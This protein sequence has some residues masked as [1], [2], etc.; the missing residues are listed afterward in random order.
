MQLFFRVV[1]CV[2]LAFAFV[3]AD[4]QQYPR[5]LL[6][7]DDAINNPAFAS[8]W[9][10]NIGVSASFN[11]IKSKGNYLNDNIYSVFESGYGLE[12][13]VPDDYVED[14]G[15]AIRTRR[16]ILRKK[17][18][19]LNSTGF[20][21]LREELSGNVVSGR[22]TANHITLS[23][24]PPSTKKFRWPS[25]GIQPGWIKSSNG[26]TKFDLNAGVAVFGDPTNVNVDSWDADYAATLNYISVSAYHLSMPFVGNSK[27]TFT[28]NFYKRIQGSFRRTLIQAYP[29]EL[30]LQGYTVYNGNWWYNA[31]AVLQVMTWAGTES[32]ASLIDHTYIG[33]AYQSTGHILYQAGLRI[34][35]PIWKTWA[36]TISAGYDKAMKGTVPSF[37]QGFEVLIS[38]MPAKF[39]NII[40]CSRNVQPNLYADS[41]R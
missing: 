19:F 12:K 9:F 23:Y 10:S 37:G 7:N 20:G 30:L 3:N 18:S 24:T 32:D 31:G 15:L 38:L 40:V 5:S 33:A 21:F 26:N 8:A 34:H 16:Q 27:D 25:F 17:L 6:I 4:A 2:V 22:A 13:F 14:T 39:D 35:E 28:S 41:R 29:V 1:I 36:V 11:K